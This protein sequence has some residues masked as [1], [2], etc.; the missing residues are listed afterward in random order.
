MK[1]TVFATE[2]I[3]EKKCPADNA[4]YSKSS[5]ELIIQFSN[6]ASNDKGEFKLTIWENM[7]SLFP[8]IA[9]IIFEHDYDTLVYESGQSKWRSY[10]G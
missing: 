1:K 5:G 2:M 3:L 6:S 7:L 9:S 10:T 8:Q 4:S